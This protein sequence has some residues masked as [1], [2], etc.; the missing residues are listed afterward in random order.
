MQKFGEYR[1]VGK[2]NLAVKRVDSS[3]MKSLRSQQTCN[4]IDV[5]RAIAG[6]WNVKGKLCDDFVC[7]LVSAAAWRL[8]QGESPSTSTGSLSIGASPGPY[9]F[10]I[11]ISAAS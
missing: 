6:W 3:N 5:A 7:L 10:S 9:D 8:F 2:S 1:G 4:K 11:S